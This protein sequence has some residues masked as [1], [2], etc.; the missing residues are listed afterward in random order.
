MSPTVAIQTEK[1]TKASPVAAAQ[2]ISQFFDLTFQNHIVPSLGTIIYILFMHF[3][4]APGIEP[5]S[6]AP[7]SLVPQPVTRPTRHAGLRLAFEF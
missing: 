6:L 3:F 1:I 4:P 5:P 2:V 7:Q